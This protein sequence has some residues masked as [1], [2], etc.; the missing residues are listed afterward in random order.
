[1]KSN[2]RKTEEDDHAQGVE[3]NAQVTFPE[4]A[5]QIIV[6][7]YKELTSRDDKLRII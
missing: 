2:Q 7:N 4:F 3:E 5:S 1:M 6:K